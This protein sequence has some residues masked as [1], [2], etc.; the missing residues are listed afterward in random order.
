MRLLVGVS[1]YKKGADIAMGGMMGGFGTGLGG[2]GALGL[3]GMIL[4][5]VI[6]I[7]LI[8]GLVLL[9]AWLWRRVNPDGEAQTTQQRPAITRNSPKEIL[10]AR[11][12]RGEITRDQY[13]Q[14][15]ADL[16]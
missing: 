3:I 11:Y 16:S 2:F 9:I 1:G 7:G 4:N 13:Q 15:L 14:M 6:T 10:Q 12:A 8:A 5:L